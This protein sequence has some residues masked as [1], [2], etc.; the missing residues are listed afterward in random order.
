[1]LVAQHQC[2]ILKQE[3]LSL[4][5]VGCSKQH[6]L[7]DGSARAI[8]AVRLMRKSTEAVLLV[9]DT[10]D[11]IKLLSTK[12]I[13]DSNTSDWI[14]H[15]SPVRKGVVANSGYPVDVLALMCLKWQLERRFTVFPDFATRAFAEAQLDDEPEVF[16]ES[17]RGKTPRLAW[18]AVF[19]AIYASWYGRIAS[20]KFKNLANLH[21]EHNPDDTHIFLRNRVYFKSGEKWSD[22][23]ILNLDEAWF[24]GKVCF[25]K[26]EGLPFSS[27]IQKPRKN[28]PM[29]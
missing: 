12:V 25:L 5:K 18:R 17:F 24:E 22:H 14:D 11:G 19:L 28:G 2:I 3:T 4:S 1:M 13:Y 27:A 10:S 23:E 29:L 26:I 16:M 7:A 8:K 15:F 6:L 21:T 20:G 9:V